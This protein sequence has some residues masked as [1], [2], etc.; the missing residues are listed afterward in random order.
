MSQILVSYITLF[1][2]LK[3]TDLHQKVVLLETGTTKPA[4]EISLNFDVENPVLNFNSLSEG[5]HLYDYKDELN[6]GETKYLYMR[7]SFK[8]AKSG[9]SDN[10]MIQS[11]PDT[12]DKIIHKLYTRY[13][14]TRTT[15]GY[16]YSIDDSYSSNVTY[17]TN[18]NGND[19]TVNLYQ[20]KVL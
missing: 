11:E 10:L 6:I 18:N 4:N 2:Y 13:K 14:L 15:T 5:Y 9:K 8:N 16:Y 20:L 1:S 19:I 12:I 17:T 3:P 7:A